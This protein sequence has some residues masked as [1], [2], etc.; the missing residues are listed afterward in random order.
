MKEGRA[1]EAKAQAEYDKQSGAA[2]DALDAQQ[3]KK[4]NTEKAIT[5]LEENIADAEQFKKDK[6]GDLGAEEDM[7]KSLL[8][9]CEWVKTNFDSRAKARAAELDGLVEAKNF[10]AGVESGNAVL[11]P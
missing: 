4:V 10:L 7:E 9:D 3:E 8:T 11:A 2:Q 6:Q 1:D 5:G